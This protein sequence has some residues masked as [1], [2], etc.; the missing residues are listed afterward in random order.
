MRGFSLVE[1]LVV[2]GI[3][4]ILI[5]ILMPALSAARR[6]AKVTQCLSNLRQLGLGFAMYQNDSVGRCFPFIESSTNYWMA[7]IAPYVG[8]L[9]DV[10]Y[11]PQAL[12]IASP[13]SYSYGGDFVAWTDLGFSGSYGMNLWICPCTMVSGNAVTPSGAEYGYTQIQDT[14]GLPAQN[15]TSVPLFADCNW[16]GGW[17][18]ETDVPSSNLDDAA[19]SNPGNQLQRFCTD[20]HGHISNA[21]FLDG[22]A[23][24]V[25]L[26]G[27]WQLE[28]NTNFHPQV[29]IIP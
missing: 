21:V 1:S 22:H 27:L 26:A 25:S 20:R 24:S 5:A 3:I 17:P 13:A 2:I 9:S 7:E 6:Q 18:L 12:T 19:G 29:V 14:I 23:E 15:S 16:V 11:C 10:R 4:S 28:W 8:N